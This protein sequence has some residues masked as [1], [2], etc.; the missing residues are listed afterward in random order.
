MSADAILELFC[1][2]AIAV[3]L[4]SYAVDAIR[5]PRK[6]KPKF[7]QASH[8]VLRPRLYDQDAAA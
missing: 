2:G 7:E 6:S 5:R 8:V 4:S 3:C 1:L